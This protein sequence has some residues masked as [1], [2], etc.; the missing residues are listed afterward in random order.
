M[1][2][3]GLGKGANAP[4]DGRRCTALVESAGVAVDVV[5]FQLAADGHV[6]SDD[7]VVFFNQPTTPEGAVT[8]T[9]SGVTVLL[10]DVPDWV[11][12]VTIAVA[13][14]DDQPTAPLPLDIQFTLT[15]ESDG[16]RCP[17]SGLTTERAAVLVELYRR[18]GMWKLR[19]VSAGWEQGL[20]A[21]FGHHG[22]TVDETTDQVNPTAPKS[23]SAD[24]R[25]GPPFAA[26]VQPE[27]P[28]APPVP[29]PLAPA[30][31]V[32]TGKTKKRLIWLAA[33]VAALLVLAAVV[34]RSPDAQKDAAAPIPLASPAVAAASSP[35]GSSER[36][37][38]AGS[39]SAPTTTATTVAA[40]LLPAP[41]PA[42]AA[43][44]AIHDRL[45]AQAAVTTLETLRVAGRAAKTGYSRAQF[46]QAWTDDAA[47][48]GGHNGCDTRNDILRRDLRQL[49][50]RTGSHG[51]VV[52][53]G[54][55]T[56]P[57]TGRS[58][59]FSV[60]KAATVQIDHV[61]SLSNAWQT[62][63][64]ALSAEQRQDFANDPLN[65]QATASAVNQ[66][67]G[68][69]DAATWLP[70]DKTYRC[71]YVA[72]QVAVKK[73]YGLWVTAAERQA[74][75]TVLV[76]CGATPAPQL[77]RPTPAT[78]A[79]TKV[80]VPTVRAPAPTVPATTVQPATTRPPVR[81]TAV[82]NPSVV[83]T[84]QETTTPPE[85]TGSTTEETTVLTTTSDASTYYSSCA[86]ARAAGAAP[87][88]TGDPGYRA[89][90][91][92]DHDGI[93]CE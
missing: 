14:A 69:G 75:S 49:T 34:A 81:T 15:T 85:T 4:I 1:E 68:D 12:A 55:F 24:D 30:P 13:V 40:R 50:I 45:S 77:A 27:P 5:T 66:A 41:A 18:N 62:G 17:T 7:D 70:P 52:T 78:T 54:G 80:P 93:A 88:H 29:T 46:G 58:L 72:R 48:D 67:K 6:R 8:S 65:L 22:V 84:E 39:S 33:T 87:L 28:Q 53:S 19:N 83:T 25:Q 59:Q 63:A 82:E 35:I 36:I 73:K 38:A 92:R 16:F 91:D 31:P 21:L 76:T 57:Y 60:G 90:L 56:D 20:A 61:V 71:T 43:V 86:D 79:P 10:D 89:G 26:P 47:V 74:I 23:P 42:P 51:C 64:D 9:G 2:L 32:R 11:V 3:R 44:A 37:A